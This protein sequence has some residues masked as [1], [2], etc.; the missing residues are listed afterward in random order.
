MA[1]ACWHEVPLRTVTIDTLTPLI[2]SY[3]QGRKARGEITAT[4]AKDYR[5]TLNGLAESYGQRPL[6]KF[7]PAAIDRWLE[8]IGHHSDATRR[9]YLS[10]VRG[11]CRWMVAQGKLRT[12]PTAHVPA[13]PQARRA[14]RTLTPEQ[15]GA[16]LRHAPDA[17]ARAVIWLMVGCGLRC[18]EVARLQVEDYDGRTI[19]VR[20]KSG[21]ERALP[22]P[23]RVAA[24]VNMY[25]D[26]VG[27]TAGPLIRSALVPSQGLSPR[28]L[29][30]YLR[31][32]MLDA[33]VKARALD[34]RS[35]HAL[36]R[37]CASD[38]ADAGADLRVVQ[39]LLGHRRLETTAASYLRR[40]TM[41]QMRE[42]MENRD[43]SEAA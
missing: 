40:V 35:A 10:K 25:L 8:T 39:E 29:S 2:V 24:A 11:F 6:D 3:V 43:Y 37:T 22:V 36:R 26:E 17:R 23:V 16:L 28:T 4:T 18:V 20:G 27:V 31:G 34:G 41:A 9:L 14:P 5:W 19:T 1:H 42:A 30:G 32:W 33:G 38:V 13:V 15:V 12:D 21:H 7:G